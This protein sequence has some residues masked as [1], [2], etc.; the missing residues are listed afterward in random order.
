M[1]GGY[2]WHWTF[3]NGCHIRFPNGGDPQN[4]TAHG[5]ITGEG[6]AAISDYA[7]N[8]LFHTDGRNLYGPPP[9]NSPVNPS[10]Q[11]L[12]GDSSSTHS[13]I[14][15]PPAGGGS[16]YHVFTVGDWADPTHIGPVRY[17]SVSL[18]PTLSVGPTT[19]LTFGPLRASERLA[20]IPHHDCERYWVVS[21]DMA[22]TSP[23]PATL[24]AMRI[25]SDAGPSAGPQTVTQAYPFT[26]TCAYSMKFSPDCSL[27][28]LCSMTSVDLLTFDRT[29]GAFG[30]HSQVTGGDPQDPIYGIEFSPNGQ[31]LY[32]TG[33]KTGT[34]WRHTIPP[35]PPVTATPIG[36]VTQVQPWALATPAAGTAQIGALQLGP[37]GKIYGAKYATPKLFEIGNPD[38]ATPAGIQ[39]NP[40]ATDNI[41]QPLAL[42]GDCYLGLPTFTRIA[43]SCRDHV[44]VEDRCARLAAQVNEQLA[45]IQKLNPLRPCDERQPIEK[46]KCAPIDLPRIAPWVSI[47]WGDSQCDCIEGDDTEVMS[48]TICN[49]YQNLTLA[50]L[51]VQMVTVVDMNGNAVPNLPDGTPSIELTPIGPYCF[52]DIA[53]CTCVT[54]Q[55]VLR[56]RGAVP[57]PH[58]ILLKGICFDAC[59]HGDED[60]CFVFNVCKD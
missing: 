15:V 33:H 11:P 31:Y 51:T 28:A 13:A 59:F 16:V 56:L 47:R 2:D 1:A 24:F 40:V 8:L 34:V 54:R 23:G 5:Y 46:P 6:C 49:P 37:N 53:P 10:N 29:S 57:G 22:S 52:G 58:R 26:A 39:F 50:G 12:G 41:G 45:G 21:L 7:G 55:F 43:D 25:D 19:A 18:S 42:T 3:G 30:P 48:L 9:A 17:T 20:A 60:A 35:S 14:I 32:F 4:D 44:P 38:S 27:L 36:S